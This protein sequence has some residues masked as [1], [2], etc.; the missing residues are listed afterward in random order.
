MQLP[1]VDAVDLS[2]AP[3]AL[4]GLVDYQPGSVVSRP[5]IKK[6]SGN[7]TLFAFDAGEGLSE[8]AAPFDAL[9]LVVEGEAEVRI[10]E[11]AHRVRAGEVVLFPAGKPHALHAPGRFKMLLSLIHAE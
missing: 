10:G 4:A 8:H 11:Q 9:V 7:L 5:L 2:A 1:N 6:K 3:R